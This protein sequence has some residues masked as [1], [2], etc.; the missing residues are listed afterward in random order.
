MTENIDT[1]TTTVTV[2]GPAKD[3]QEYVYKAKSGKVRKFK[4]KEGYERFLKRIQKLKEDGKSGGR[5]E[6][7]Q[8]EPVQGSGNTSAPSSALT[9]LDNDE[10]KKRIEEEKKKKD[11]ETAI[12]KKKDADVKFQQTVL[13][14]A[15]IISSAIIVIL[16]FVKP[17][18]PKLFGGGKDDSGSPT[19]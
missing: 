15:I 4:T 1:N 16:F 18:F 19:A 5:P 7:H 13:V 9:V 8:S 6:Q 14:I 2:S 10:E 3:E 17:K 12:S 11:E